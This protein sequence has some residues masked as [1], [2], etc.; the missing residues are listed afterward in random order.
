MNDHTHS[1]VASSNNRHPNSCEFYLDS[2]SDSD[3]V[4]TRQST[5]GKTSYSSAMSDMSGSDRSSRSMSGSDRSSSSHCE[6]RRKRMQLFMAHHSTLP[7]NNP[8]PWFSRS[9]SFLDGAASPQRQN[10]HGNFLD[11]VTEQP[12]DEA[13]GIEKETPKV[14]VIRRRRSSMKK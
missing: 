10:S 8:I 5:P 3:R 2:S 9:S 7:K 1:F 14:I 4:R 6:W 11:R 12:N 13:K